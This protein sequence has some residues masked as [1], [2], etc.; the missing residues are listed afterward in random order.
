VINN[1]GQLLNVTE[2]VSALQE[3]VEQSEEMG[4]PVGILTTDNRNNWGKAYQD[5]ILGFFI[6]DHF[7]IKYT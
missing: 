2:I 7:I 1:F 4:P 6:Y 5:L 3:I